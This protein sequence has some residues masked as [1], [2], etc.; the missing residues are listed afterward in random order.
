MCASP[1]LAL[2]RALDRIF[3]G[4][5]ASVVCA[6]IGLCTSAAVVSKPQLLM[7]L[8]PAHPFKMLPLVKKHLMRKLTLAKD[9]KH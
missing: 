4:F 8:R 7:K 6:D 3:Q 1:R 9:L 2:T 5:P